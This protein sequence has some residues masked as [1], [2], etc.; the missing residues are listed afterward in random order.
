MNN[1]KLLYITN[2][3]N[4]SG[5]LERVL[6]IKVNYLVEKMNYEVHIMVLNDGDKQPFYNFSD[7]IIYHAVPATGNPLS[8]FI[9]YKKGIKKIITTI[10][11]DIISV[12]DDGLKG[13]L[14][15]IIFD[16]KTPVIYERH[17]SFDI[18]KKNDKTS[19]NQKIK[20]RVIKS[21]MKWGAQKFDKFIVL[22]KNNLK[23]W[24][25]PNMQ[26]IP[27]PL[28]FYP[29]EV[30][31]LE[32]F[33]VI[34]V[35]SHSFTKGFDRLITVWKEINVKY[36]NWILEIYGKKDTNNSLQKLIETHKLNNSVKLYN[37]VKNIQ[38]KYMDA[39]IFVLPSRSEGFG[40]V[41][42]EAMSCGLPCV[43]FDC[44]S[45]PSDIISD[46]KDGFLIE[47][48]NIKGFVYKLE[49]LME[50]EKLRKKMGKQARENVQAYNV[51]VIAKQWNEL[52][53]NLKDNK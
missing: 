42:I 15:P 37:P 46:N 24:N 23:E 28:S 6:S 53:I 16:T 20:L 9:K 50:D 34:A 44:P 39:S 33:K 30:S 14:F 5:G 52:F 13:M 4:G 7:K 35:G 47:N 8:Y 2:G 48:G 19:F 18:L 36:P 22:T 41:L 1:I 27:N 17:A 43:S 26:V 49:L 21:L 32:N 45:G 29:T 40:M 31:T 10:N 25:L 3:I 51:D 38:Q 11:P 12:C